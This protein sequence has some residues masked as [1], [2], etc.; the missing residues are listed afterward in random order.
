[1]SSICDSVWKSVEV[2]EQA[3]HYSYKWQAAKRAAAMWNTDT[4]LVWYI[5]TAQ[6]CSANCNVPQP[7]LSEMLCRWFIQVSSS[8]KITNGV[9]E[10]SKGQKSHRLYI[11]CKALQ[12]QLSPDRLWQHTCQYNSLTISRELKQV[13][14]W[15]VMC[16]EWGQALLGFCWLEKTTSRLHKAQATHCPCVT[17]SPRDIPHLC[18]LCPSL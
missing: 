2:P 6:P 1:M 4:T 7:S 16:T 8:G 3:L 14:A 9:Y 10:C 13:M 15:S 17:S 18:S 11:L 12:T 5:P